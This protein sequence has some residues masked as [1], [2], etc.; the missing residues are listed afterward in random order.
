LTIAKVIVAFVC[1]FAV[2]ADA[3]QLAC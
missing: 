2:L 3:E 1:L